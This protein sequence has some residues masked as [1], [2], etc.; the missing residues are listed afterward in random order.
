MKKTAVTC[1]VLLFFVLGTTGCWNLREPDQLAY[2]MGAG[3][4]Y[5]K[6]GQ[7]EISSQIAIPAS[8]GG[9]QGASG[10]D[11]KRFLVVSARGKNIMDAGQK[12][13][14]QLSRSLFYGHRQTILIGHQMAEHGIGNLVD[15]F[16]RNPKSEIRSTIIVVKDGQ[17][18]EALSIEPNFDPFISTTF[19]QGQSVVGIKPY[20]YRQ[21]LIDALS[22]ESQLMIPAISLTPS[23]KYVYAG[24]AIL[25]KD[26]G[27]KLVGY[28]N[29]EES[30]LANW[31]VG[32][33]TDFTIT[34]NLNQGD[35][36]VSLRLQ[37]LDNHILATKKNENMEIAIHLKGTGTVV[38]N[39]SSMDPS[40]QNELQLIQDQL[41]QS[42]QQSV[43]QVIEKVQKRY[44]ADILEL[45]EEIHRQYPMEWKTM[46][47]NWNRVFPDLQ[48]TVKVE[49]KIKDP[50]Q[51]NVPIL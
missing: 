27:L 30:S 19:V 14:V 40:K 36:N 23:K 4:D 17:A 11:K 35:G 8:I 32:R 34:S 9:E 46:Q 33:Q 38:E 48:V 45:G 1:F 31:I 7:F 49:L 16:V 13:Q 18:K 24:S 37:K 29:A 43:K 39:N 25:R 50:G 12:L 28:L 2:I 15:M 44:K 21:L 3:M 47:G 26:D 5:T 42:T 6:D 20:Y 22:P 41:S 10:N 51:T